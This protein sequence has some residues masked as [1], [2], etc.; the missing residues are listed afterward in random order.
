MREFIFLAAVVCS[1]R[2]VT[3]RPRSASFA[4]VIGLHSSSRTV[5]IAVIAVV[6]FIPAILF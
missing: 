4:L 3:S 1:F 2:W 5:V 6:P